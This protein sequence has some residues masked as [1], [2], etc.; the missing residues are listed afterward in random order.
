VTHIE[1]KILEPSCPRCKMIEGRVKDALDELG[2]NAGVGDVI[3]LA[4]LNRIRHYFDSS[5]CHK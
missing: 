1:I 4:R 5:A 3:G 2:I